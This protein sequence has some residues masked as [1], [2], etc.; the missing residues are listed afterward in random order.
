MP[1]Y[2]T[3]HGATCTFPTS[4]FVAAFISFGGS[5][6]SREK[7][8]KSGLATTEYRES[9]PG[10]LTD[11]GEFSADFFYDPDVQPPI[12]GP[13]ETIVLKVGP[14]PGAPG[15]GG[16]APAQMSGP[17]FVREWTTPELATDTILRCSMTIAWADGPTFTD[18]IAA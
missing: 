10:D 15:A 5:T 4:T 12:T 6:F 2:D 18:A 1:V 11:P 9:K 16:G 7:L 17:A 3:G 8:D 14:D 13:V